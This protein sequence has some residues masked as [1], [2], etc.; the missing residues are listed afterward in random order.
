MDIDLSKQVYTFHVVYGTEKV[1]FS[2]ERL[3]MDTYVGLGY[4]IKSINKDKVPSDIALNFHSPFWYD[5]YPR[6]S[7][8]S[9]MLGFKIGYRL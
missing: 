1:L 6:Y 9:L 8:P 5:F 7:I 2:N 3:M 4:R